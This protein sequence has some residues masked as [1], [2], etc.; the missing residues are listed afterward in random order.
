MRNDGRGAPQ[1]ENDRSYR[2]GKA[3]MNWTDEAVTTLTR[4]WDE[5]LSASQIGAELGVSRC[6]VL[7]K[8]DRLGLPKRREQSHLVPKLAPQ[9]LLAPIIADIDIPQAQRVASVLDLTHEH[10]RW[11]VGDPGTPNFFFC[12]ARPIEGLSYCGAHCRVAYRQP[13]ERQEVAA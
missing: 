9:P 1:P 4:M 11:P 10:C 8:I 13:G 6:A 3:M 7:G 2:R 5:G 12:G